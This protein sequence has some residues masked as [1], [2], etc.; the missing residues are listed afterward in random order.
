MVIAIGHNRRRARSSSFTTPSD[1]S[2]GNYGAGRTLVVSLLQL[3]FFFR[4]CFMIYIKPYRY[5]AIWPSELL[6]FGLLAIQTS[7]FWTSDFWLSRLRTSRLWIRFLAFRFLDIR[8]LEYRLQ[9]SGPPD[10]WPS[11]LISQCPENVLIGTYWTY[12]AKPISNS[13]RSPCMEKSWLTKTP[14][15]LTTMLYVVC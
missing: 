1:S 5:L 7:D 13:Y 3:H 2:S 9:T 4:I 15:T 14:T 11:G 10:F 8:I 6:D 12:L